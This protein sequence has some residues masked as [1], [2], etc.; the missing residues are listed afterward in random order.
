MRQ[1]ILALMILAA[2][3][4]G[5]RTDAL[6]ETEDVRLDMKIARTSC[7]FVEAKFSTDKDAYY[8]VSIEKVREG[9]DPMSIQNQFK[10][11]LLWST[12]TGSISTGDSSTSITERS[13]LRNSQATACSTET[14]TN[15][16]LTS[17]R[18]AITGCSALWWTPIPT[19]LAGN[20]CWRRFTPR[21]RLR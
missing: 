19:N 2:L 13:I 16:S 11:L 3:F 8:Y 12:H 1:R 9:V 6:Y 4:A 17:I 10:T 18:T 20:S 5:C 14:R 7:G 15:S 21:N